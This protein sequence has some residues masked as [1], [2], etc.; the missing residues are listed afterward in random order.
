MGMPVQVSC[1]QVRALLSACVVL[2]WVTC[3]LEFFF[4]CIPRWPDY[5]FITYSRKNTLTFLGT[6]LLWNPCFHLIF[7]SLGRCG[8]PQI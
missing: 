5:M 3:H 2:Y 4:V 7:Q 1:S 6:R 8:S